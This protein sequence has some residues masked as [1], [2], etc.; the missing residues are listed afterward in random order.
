MCRRGE[1]SKYFA[2]KNEFQLMKL[3]RLNRAIGLKFW[4]R[5]STQTKT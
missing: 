2:T 3:V 1:L 5:L 4:I